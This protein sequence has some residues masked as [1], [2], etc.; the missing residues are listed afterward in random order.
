MHKG[1]SR[2]NGL[3]E[4]NYPQ[5]EQDFINAM[6]ARYMY[7]KWGIEVGYPVVPLYLATADFQVAR[8]QLESDC[9]SLCELSR[10]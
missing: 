6:Y 7:E 9:G 3:R 10:M 4:N 8:W 2:L 5:A 1:Y